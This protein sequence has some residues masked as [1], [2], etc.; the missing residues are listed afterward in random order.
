[1]EHIFFMINNQKT[2]TLFIHSHTHS[3][4]LVWVNAKRSIH[5]KQKGCFVLAVLWK[6]EYTMKTCNFNFLL[7]TK[8]IPLVFQLNTAVMYQASYNSLPSDLLQAISACY[9]AKLWNGPP[10]AATQTFISWD[11]WLKHKCSIPADQ[12]ATE[13]RL[14][15]GIITR[16]NQNNP[17]HRKS[18]SEGLVWEEKNS[19]YLQ[20]STISGNLPKSY[21]YLNMWLAVSS[22]I[23]HY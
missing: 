4:P 20:P 1:M 8:S 12:S 7:L 11:L 14:E 21:C 23:H 16:K 22:L 3:A 5:W 10:S 17:S 2:W 19:I 18:I 6:D 13:S 15:G 9:Q